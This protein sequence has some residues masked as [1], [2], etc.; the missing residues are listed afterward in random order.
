MSENALI[1]LAA[2]LFYPGIVLLVAI[3]GPHNETERR[4]LRQ[5]GKR[6]KS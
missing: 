6:R 5:R 3:T 2:I 4:E 1:M